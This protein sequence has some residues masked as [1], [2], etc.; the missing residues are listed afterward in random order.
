[1]PVVERANSK[2]WVVVAGLEPEE[3]AGGGPRERGV[4]Q[5]IRRAREDRAEE[6]VRGREVHEV[7]RRAVVEL[8]EPAVHVVHE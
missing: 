8:G 5:A 2:A 6:L 4:D 1:M 3:Q 7:G